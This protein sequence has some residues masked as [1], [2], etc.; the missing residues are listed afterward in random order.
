MAKVG[1]LDRELKATGAWVFVGG[2]HAPDKSAV[3]RIDGDDVVAADG[4][5]SG[6][7]EYIGGFWVIEVPSHESALD[8]ARKAARACDLPVEVRPFQDQITI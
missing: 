5:F 4:P 7:E 2:L 1:V 6:D 8:W 3:L